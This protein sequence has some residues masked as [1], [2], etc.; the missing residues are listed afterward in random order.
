MCQRATK[1]TTRRP[2]CCASAVALQELARQIDDLRRSIPNLKGHLEVNERS[3]AE[4]QRNLDKARAT[5]A[6][7]EPDVAAVRRVGGLFA[8]RLHV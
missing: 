4:A 7:L 6:A 5:V 8:V 2:R 3:R 1:L